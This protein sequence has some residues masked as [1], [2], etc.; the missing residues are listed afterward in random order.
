LLEETKAFLQAVPAEF[1]AI[2]QDFKAAVCDF[3]A[4]LQR[5]KDLLAR[6]DPEALL[7]DL[8]DLYEEEFR[9]RAHRFILDI[10]TV[11]RDFSP[12]EHASHRRYF[13]TALRDLTNDSAFF[14]RASEK[15]LGYAGD[16][17]MMELLYKGTRAGDTAW[18]KA[19]NSCLT[20]I[21]L[22]QAV[23][24]RAWYLKGWIERTASRQKDARVM[25]LACG[26][27]E[28]VRLFATHAAVR[29]AEFFLVDQDPQAILYAEEQMKALRGITRN[30]FHFSN[31]ST[32]NF[33][34]DPAHARTYPPMHLVYTAGLYDYLNDEAAAA[35]TSVLYGM[36]VPGATLVV[37]NFIKD[38][39]F[40]YFIEYASDWFLMHRSAEDLLAL[41][42]A[43]VLKEHRWVEREPSGVNLFLCIQK[44]RAGLAPRGHGE[45]MPS[46][47]AED[48]PKEDKS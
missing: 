4:Y 36:L 22:G 23:R 48:Q 14:K 19:V 17:L 27:C 2:R 35:L 15:P 1:V 26:P 3:R 30:V 12:V 11:I 45:S 43:D 13:Q 46:S 40:A 47:K 16:Y 39:P 42:P 21:P 34:K 28:E 6:P 8:L 38:H 5:L 7:S 20:S 18:H 41:A 31:D 44:P 32:R 33:L 25:S 24:N 29:Q 10:S 37:G 9:E